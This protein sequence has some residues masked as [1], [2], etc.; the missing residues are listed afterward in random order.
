MSALPLVILEP[1]GLYV[2]T[3]V[4]RSILANSLS[5]TPFEMNY[6]QLG[7]E[8]PYTDIPISLRE[9]VH[10]LFVFRHWMSREEVAL[11]PSLKVV[12]RMGVGYDR[13]DRAA[14][15]E[16]GVIVCNCPDYGTTEVADHAIALALSLRRGILLHHDAQ[17]RIV[18]SG[19]STPSTPAIWEQIRSPLIQRS[20]ASRTFTVLGLGRIGTAVALR[21]KALGWST[22]LFYDPYIPAGYERALGIERARSL[23]ELFERGD[24]VSV[25]CPL[26]KETRNLVG[27]SLVEV[28]K[29]GSVLI[30]TARGAIV[31]LDAVEWGLRN[32]LLSGVGLDTLPEEPIPDPPHPLIAA[33]QRGE[34]WLR[35]RLVITPHSAFYS[36][37]SWE[38]I[39]TLSYET[40]RDVLLDGTRRNVISIDDE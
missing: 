8:K 21:A 25:H 17:R 23:K 20:S 7:E 16:R 35:G 12:V 26:T 36:P 4:E 18:Y 38:D 31:N 32:G 2:P 13:L 39:R 1:E 28:M 37:E 30:N 19:M 24:V 6:A 3:D 11:F 34:E 40:M 27:R 10:G 14:L 9:R 22:V 5:N 33:Y 29:E 15:H